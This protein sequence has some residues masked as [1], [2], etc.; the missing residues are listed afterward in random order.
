MRLL[1]LVIAGRYLPVVFDRLVL[2]SAC[3]VTWASACSS[4]V[5]RGEPRPYRGY[6]SRRRQAFAL[7]R[8]LSCCWLPCY[9][10]GLSARQ[11]GS[12]KTY[13]NG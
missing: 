7:A 4:S 8:V 1:R 6:G 10:L 9:P 11:I 13:S 5:G 12:E 3:S 2:V